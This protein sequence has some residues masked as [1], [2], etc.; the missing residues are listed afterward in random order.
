[1]GAGVLVSTVALVLVGHHWNMLLG[2]Q[3]QVLE[4]CLAKAMHKASW[5][6]AFGCVQATDV[7]TKG[8][9]FA[10]VRDWSVH[11]HWVV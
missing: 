3:L 10:V 2:R 8:S 5:D 1:M 7:V 6:V 11:C 4:V 9:R